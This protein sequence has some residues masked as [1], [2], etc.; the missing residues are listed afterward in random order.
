M[1]NT[2]LGVVALLLLIVPGTAVNAALLRVHFSGPTA[3]PSEDWTGP[4][5]SPD[6]FELAF[7]FDTMSFASSN[8][9]YIGGETGEIQSYRFNG[10]AVQWGFAHRQWVRAVE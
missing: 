10:I 7:V 5:P 3:Y 9:T 6:S 4:G 2:A 1:K 8:Y